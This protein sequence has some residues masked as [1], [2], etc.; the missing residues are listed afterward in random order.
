MGR[1]H[2]CASIWRAPSKALVPGQATYGHAPTRRV[3]IL[4]RG[5]ATSCRSAIHPAPQASPNAVIDDATGATP[6]PGATARR[7]GCDLNPSGNGILAVGRGC[8]R[9]AAGV[10]VTPVAAGTYAP[11]L[12]KDGAQVPG[13]TQAGA[14]AAGA[15]VPLGADAPVRNQCRDPA[16]TPAPAIAAATTPATVGADGVAIVAEG[17]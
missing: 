14:A 11:R 6:P 12:P 9:I 8:C 15:P 7:L 17:T 4:V 3:P 10:T 16:P 1:C 5:T 13:A 2:G